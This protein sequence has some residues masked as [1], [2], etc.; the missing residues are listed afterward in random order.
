MGSIVRRMWPGLVVAVVAVG[1][2][3]VGT[4]VGA[5]THTDASQDKTQL[6]AARPKLFAIV[7]TNGHLYASSGVTGSARAGTGNYLVTFNRDVHKCAAVVSLGG[8]QLSSSA[9]TGISSGFA[10]A[11][12]LGHTVSVLTTRDTP[13]GGP[14]VDDEIFHL[15]VDC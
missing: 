12:P 9:S 11:L 15:I 10:G 1:V 8:Y 4:S 7:K 3:A 13:S 2:T 6:G 14:T 5:P